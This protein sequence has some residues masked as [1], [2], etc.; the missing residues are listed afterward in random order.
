MIIDIMIFI[1]RG[2]FEFRENS[3]RILG[4]KKMKRICFCFVVLLISLLTGCSNAP[5]VTEIS[6]ETMADADPAEYIKELNDNSNL[7]MELNQDSGLTEEE[8]KQYGNDNPYVCTNIRKAISI[9]F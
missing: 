3:R 4:E 7:G 6:A 5:E 2:K 1:R 9:L 8:A